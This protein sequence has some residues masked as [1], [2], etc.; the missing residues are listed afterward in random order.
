MQ[1]TRSPPLTKRWRMRAHR[2]ENWSDSLLHRIRGDILAKTG[3]DNCTLAEEA[4]LLAFRIAQDQGARSFGLQAALKLA[5]RYLGEAR[6]SEAR[7][8]LSAALDGLPPF[9]EL[10]EVDEAR[11][12]LSTLA[13]RA[14]PTR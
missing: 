12:L 10:P 9:S 6:A 13:E 1:A 5:K 7:E 11:G 2:G 14:A 4:Y 8:I 3:P